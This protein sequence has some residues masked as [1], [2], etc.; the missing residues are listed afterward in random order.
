MGLAQRRHPM[1]RSEQARK[2]GHQILLLWAALIA[3]A[4]ALAFLLPQGSGTDRLVLI[5][6]MVMLGYVV[7][8]IWLRSPILSLIGLGVTLAALAGRHWIPPREFLLWM[9]I[10]GGG[11]LFVPGLYVRLRWK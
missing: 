2:L 3:Y 4:I 11:G 8:G 7:M 6:S 10:F 5:V 1:V 9:A